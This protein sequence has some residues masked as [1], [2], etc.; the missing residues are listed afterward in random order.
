MN[1]EKGTS[2]KE[3]FFFPH[4]FK[5]LEFLRILILITLS[6]NW[7]NHAINKKKHV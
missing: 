6:F 1:K 2:T 3:I 4:E 7:K 5:L